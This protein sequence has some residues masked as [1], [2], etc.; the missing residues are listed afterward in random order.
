MN[1]ENGYTMKLSNDLVKIFY[2]DIPK[3]VIYKAKLLLLD[4]IGYTLYAY[5]EEAAE[6]ITNVI[7][8]LGGNPESTIIGY[9]FKSSCLLAALA[10]GAMGH[11]AE[12][13]DTHAASGTHPGDSI[14]SASL[15]I[16]E[17][18]EID[19]KCFL[20]S[21]ISGYEAELRIGG[22]IAPSH[23]GRGFHPSGTI[24]TFGAAVA[25]GRMFKFNA[26][27][28]AEVLGL[29]G[30]QASGFLYYLLEGVRMPK[31]FNTGRAAF[32]GV[33]AALLVK[34][35]F[36][37]GKTVLESEKGFCKLFSDPFS[38]KMNRITDRVGKMYKIMEVSHKMYSSCRH[39][40]SS[41]EAILT[42][43][44]ENKI[45]INEIEE[46]VARIMETGAIYVNDPE[47]WLPNR[48]VYGSRFSA[49]FN[50][51]V[52][53]LDGEEG[54]YKLIDRDYVRDKLSSNEIRNIMK[55]IKI[56]SD[57]ELDKEYPYKWSTIVEVKKGNKIYSA[58]VDFPKGEPQ[59]PVSEKEVIDKFRR[60]TTNIF[61]NERDIEKIIHFILNVEKIKNIKEI[62]KFLEKVRR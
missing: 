40:H 34:G 42:I 51:A 39:T 3:E 29:A 60:I 43:I 52:A 54:I 5:K 16:G 7:R 31:D 12:L 58:R 56:I 18:E 8:E 1:I 48:G 15:A 24:N 6:I 11:M 28:I 57:Q 55:K 44:K 26:S 49:Q 46:V 32:S 27:K 50:I 45:A 37:G 22:A 14:I 59:N 17:R 35:G 61:E 33:L 21:M 20:E 41:I 30:L 53:I 47:P 38:I 19:G 13:D 23:F 36:Q 9:G 62:F 25:A 4:Y 10:N 2:E